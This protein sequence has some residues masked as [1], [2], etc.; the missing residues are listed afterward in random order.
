MRSRF[1]ERTYVRK[2][3]ENNQ[4]MLEFDLWSPHTCTAAHNHA[5]T[6]VYM[7]V[8]THIHTHSVAHTRK[9]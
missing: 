4:E 1:C 6:D 5:H 2:K 8:H 3:M 9:D 7:H